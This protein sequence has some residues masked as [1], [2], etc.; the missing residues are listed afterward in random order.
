MSQDPGP[1]RQDPPPPPPP[2]PRRRLPAMLAVAAAVGL[3]IWALWRIFPETV[4][5]SDDWADVARAALVVLIVGTAAFRLRHGRWTEHLRHAAAWLAI[6]AVLA[7]GYAYRDELRGVLRKVQGAFGPGVPM[8]TAAHELVVNQDD[9]GGYIV[10]GHVNGQRVRFLVDTGSSDT[11]LAPADAQRL[12]MDV[13]ALTYSRTAETANGLG[14][15]A[16]FTADSLSVGPIRLDNVPM[17]INQTPMSASLLGMT[18]LSRLDAFEFR[19]RKL[20]L[21]WRDAAAPNP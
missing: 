8:A 12:G 17:V 3:A 15:G 18:F 16:P 21:R 4:R 6:I 2:R 19:G 10:I 5:T 7:L 11:V 13:K 9:E 1:W 20:Y 14:Y